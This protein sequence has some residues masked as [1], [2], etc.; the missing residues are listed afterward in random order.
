MNIFKT[1][2]GNKRS[3]VWAIVTVALV[4]LLVVVDVLAMHFSN[5]ISIFLGGDRPYEVDA[6]DAVVYYEK[7]TA[8]K[9]EANEQARAVTREIAEEGTI[10]LKN[11]G[12]LP[13][14]GTGLKVSV[15]GKNSV[16]LVYGGSGSG[17]G[18][19]TF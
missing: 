15:F 2:F 18:D 13:L 14:T 17:G 3:R 9:D 11:N 7:S 6:E 4:V 12:A 8:S 5:I 10:M 16:N 1:I 19:T